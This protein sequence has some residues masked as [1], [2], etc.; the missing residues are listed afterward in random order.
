MGIDDYLRLGQVSLETAFFVSVPVL[1]LGLIAGLGVSIFQ[2]A[3][4]INDSA[5]AFLPKIVAAMIGLMLFGNFMIS[6]L[7]AF[8]IW[9]YGQIGTV[10]P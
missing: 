1:A 4:Q 2:A 3:T 7:A 6:K 5:L 8:T 9:T 10:T